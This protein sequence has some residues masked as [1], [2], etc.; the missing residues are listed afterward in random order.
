MKA[1]EL[2]HRRHHGDSGGSVP[3]HS[4]LTSPSER[5]YSQSNTQSSSP[6]LFQNCSP[7]P[8]RNHLRQAEPNSSNSSI[9]SVRATFESLFA[10]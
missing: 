4:S 10:P 9:R 2:L 7:I 8:I 6:D 3:S 1:T 5:S